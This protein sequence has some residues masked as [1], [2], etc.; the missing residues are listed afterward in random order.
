M[1]GV[2]GPATD[3]TRIPGG[4]YLKPHVP[5][6][7]IASAP[8]CVREVYDW[9]V[10]EANFADAQ[11]GTTIVR[12]G[13]CVRSYRDIQEGLA[14]YRGWLKL[15]YTK[16]D[17][18]NALKTLKKAG[19]IATTKTT[20]GLVIT[21]LNYDVSQDP[22]SYERHTE[23][24]TITTRSPQT[25]HTINKKNKKKNKEEYSPQFE[26]FYTSYPNRCA[27]LAA[28]R[29]WQK[30]DPQDETCQAIL[31]A[32]EMQKAHKAA[33]KAKREFCPEWPMPATWLNGRR[34]ED[35]VPEASVK[36]RLVD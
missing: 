2:Q 34:W 26:S 15:T 17:L 18:E 22:A 9:L 14:W 32:I 24:G 29:A 31:A 33:L 1:R 28:Y 27:K 13:Q 3:Q 16:S 11:V 20:R 5:D 30:I 6:P 12:R 21:V 8:P 4:Y 25:C 35:E 23:D 36:R 10:R 7:R 19:M